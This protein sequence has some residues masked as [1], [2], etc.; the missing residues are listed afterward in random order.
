M[1]MVK[2]YF[3][4]TGTQLTENEIWIDE[5]ILEKLITLTNRRNY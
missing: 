3:N 2:N 5:K 1:R 4:R